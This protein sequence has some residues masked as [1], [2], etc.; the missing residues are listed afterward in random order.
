VSS[1]S[2]IDDPESPRTL[3]PR[4]LESV[5]N[6]AAADEQVSAVPDAVVRIWPDRVVVALVAIVPA[7]VTAVMLGQRALVMAAL[8]LWGVVALSRAAGTRRIVASTEQRASD[9]RIS[10]VFG[11]TISLAGVF[12]FMPIGAARGALI[13]V[14]VAAVSMA[15]ARGLQPRELKAR[16]IVL[17]GSQ[18]EVTAYASAG[19][20][21]DLVAGCLVTDGGPTLS[22]QP[23]LQPTLKPNL[24][25]PTTHSLQTLPQ[26]VTS[27]EADAILVLPGVDVTAEVVRDLTWMFEDSHVTIGVLC[28][29]SSVSAHR[30]RTT[31]SGTSTVLELGVPRATVGARITKAVLDR[32]G[33]AFLLLLTAPLLMVLWAAVRLDTKGPGFFV[34][35]RMGKNSKP[36][37]MYKMRTMHR[38]AES[39]LEAL[40]SENESDGVLFKIRRDPRVT[41]VGY[42]L[43]R[44]SLDE[45]PQLFNVLRGEMSL[46]G[47]RPA[48]PDEVAE[49]DDVARRRL[50]VKP[51]ITGLWQVSG[52]SD[53]LW[54]ESL[55][56]DL[57]YADNWRIVDDLSI[58]A[59]TIAAVAQ[60]RG[61]Y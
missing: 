13:V 1:S 47:P 32:V 8:M 7:T 6:V 12:G 38:D 5:P 14:A 39:L 50:V 22:A 21:P 42:W 23:T 10:L 51:G 57:Y 41:R 46:V 25:V 45:L 34:Q 61:A 37:R 56:L 53:L 49:Y 17:V 55:R 35:T 33:G 27:V 31:I 11:G 28:P 24:L 15:L 43:R 29:I 58:A 2:S 60:A 19:L 26:L 36:F 9:L 44:S 40:A 52:R 48:L 59:R 54:D 30:L 18:R 20:T 3:A 4:P 16:R